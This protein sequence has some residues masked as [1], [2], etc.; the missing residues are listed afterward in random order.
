MHSNGPEDFI[1]VRMSGL[2]LAIALVSE[3]TGTQGG[4]LLAVSNAGRSRWIPYPGS[5]CLPEFVSVFRLQ[6]QNTRGK[7]PTCHLTNAQENTTAVTNH[8]ACVVPFLGGS[9][10]ETWGFV[11]A[12][13]LVSH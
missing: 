5:D 9:R 3:L 7:L 4:R 6:N 13:Q 8:N 12:R 11:H 10:D 2:Q 1:P